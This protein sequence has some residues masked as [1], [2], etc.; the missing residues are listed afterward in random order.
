MIT[1]RGLPCEYRRKS[2]ASNAFSGKRTLPGSLITEPESD[3]RPVRK[4][5]IMNRTAPEYT[6][7]GSLNKVQKH[8]GGQTAYV[9]PPRIFSA[10]EMNAGQAIRRLR[11]VL[12]RQH[13]AISTETTY[14]FWL[15]RYMLAISGYPEGL[16]SEQKLERFLTE[17]ASAITASRLPLRTKPSTPFSSSTEMSL[18]SRSRP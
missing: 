9:L 13:K 11:E 2:L 10:L 17:L 3:R 12:C 16:T 6:A 5:F 1:F 14:V 4:S 18:L 15:R 8:R 7:A